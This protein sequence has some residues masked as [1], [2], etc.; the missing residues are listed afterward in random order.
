MYLFNCPQVYFKL[1]PTHLLI[2]YLF[3][4]LLQPAT[5]QH[6][7][8]RPSLSLSLPLCLCLFLMALSALPNASSNSINSSSGGN[9]NAESLELE[10]AK[11][12]AEAEAEVEANTNSLHSSSGASGASGASASGSNH[13]VFQ[14][15]YVI[16]S[17]AVDGAEDDDHGRSLKRVVLTNSSITCNDGSH[18]GFYLRKQPNSKKWIVFLEGGWHCFD[19]RS[20]RARWMRLRHL[21]T[22]SQ[23]P[24]T[25]DGK[26]DSKEDIILSSL[27]SFYMLFP[28]SSWW[29]SVAA[30]RGESLLAQCQPCAGAI[31]QQ[32]L[33]VGHTCGA[34]ESTGS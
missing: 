19:D 15:K 18:A 17:P 6:C 12:E 24:E 16:M 9:D 21:M 4:F 31:L 8:L 3:S 13:N 28:P 2:V 11:A 26:R 5:Q 27:Y 33:L 25:R 10:H 30:C 34:S 29:H 20:C 1:L 32:R 7:Q 23:W 14:R 22:S